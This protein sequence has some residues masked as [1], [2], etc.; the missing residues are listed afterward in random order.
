M[1]DEMLV[2]HLSNPITSHNM[3][4][5]KIFQKIDL[6]VYYFPLSFVEI[7][8]FCTRSTLP[9]LQSQCQEVSDLDEGSVHRQVKLIVL[10]REHRY[11]LQHRNYTLLNELDFYQNA[12]FT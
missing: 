1:L 7:Y 12:V 6:I 10:A 2:F 8:W 5:I 3:G 9:L 11:F 4:N